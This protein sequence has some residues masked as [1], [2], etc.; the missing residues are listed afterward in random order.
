[1][2]GPAF[3]GWLTTDAAA[4]LTGYQTPHIRQLARN[5]SIEGR[6][7][8]RD[9]LV[10]RESLLRYKARMDALG[11]EKHNPWRG[12]LPR[13]RGRDKDEQAETE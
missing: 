1:M 9:W 13:G 3:E 4:E 2:T 11:S 5:G 10:S 6:K 12:D 7:V 8:G